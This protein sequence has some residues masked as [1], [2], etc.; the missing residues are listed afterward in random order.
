MRH[1]AASRSDRVIQALKRMIEHEGSIQRE[2]GQDAE[3]I[4]RP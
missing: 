2:A 1:G 4:G 3:M